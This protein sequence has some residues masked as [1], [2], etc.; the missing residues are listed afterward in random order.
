MRLEELAH[1][2]TPLRI[3]HLVHGLN[4]GGIENW[5]L[6]ALRHTPHDRFVMDVCYKGPSPGALAADARAASAQ[7]LPCPLGPTVWPFVRQLKKLLHCGRYSL[8]HVHTHAHSGPAVF[9]A[10]AAG[11]PVVTTFHN[12]ERAPQT[13]L[14]CLPGIRTAREVYVRWS[15]RYALLNSTVSNGVSAGVVEAATKAARVPQNRCELFHLG[16]AR[17]NPVSVE[18]IAEYRRALHVPEETRVVVHVG[19]FRPYKN[20]SG[21]L[22]VF[23][24]IVDA[25]PG[26]VL[27]LIGDGPLRPTIQ[28]RIDHL[29]LG[30]HVRLLGT[31]Q[32]ATALMQL[33]DVFLYPSLHEGLSIA[34]L[35]ASA[36]GLPIVASDIPGNRA[37]TDSGVSARLH[38]VTDTDGMATSVVELL[39]NP[40]EGRRLA[41]LGR[42]IYE[43]G[44]SI[45]ASV[46]RLMTLYDRVL[47]RSEHQHR[48]VPIA[49]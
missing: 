24:K 42:D 41:E 23:R 13:T 35:E 8:L 22:Q 29:E 18:R 14:T 49:A 2:D 44:F 3:L 38:D 4:F 15:I 9:A 7:L 47:Q 27:L 16:C 34:L 40:S 10:K 6:A 46:D 19:S 30:R 32:D 39:R 5:V 48:A 1:I 37:A 28:E 17:P 12:T 20:H 11:V 26:A 31:R 33:G 21:L 36:V 25:M 43:R 45:E